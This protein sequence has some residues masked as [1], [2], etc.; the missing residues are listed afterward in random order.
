MSAFKLSLA[1][2]KEERD[3]LPQ[4]EE[5]MNKIKA[6]IGDDSITLDLD[7]EALSAVEDF[8]FAGK[9]VFHTFNTM[10]VH[11]LIHIYT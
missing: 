5:Y 8:C 11:T 10:Y 7:L 1:L 9:F 6:S 4:R 3:S 2:R